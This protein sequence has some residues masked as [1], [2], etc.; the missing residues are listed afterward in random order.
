MFYVIL[1]GSTKAI[2]IKQEYGY[3]P[4]VVSTFYD[5]GEFGEVTLYQVSDNLTLDMVTELN[6]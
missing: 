4:F 3:I 1:R 5:G 2:L 6:K